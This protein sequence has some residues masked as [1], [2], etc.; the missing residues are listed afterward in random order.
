MQRTD[1]RM[2]ATRCEERTGI[3]NTDR[4]HHARLVGYEDTA[5]QAIQRTENGEPARQHDQP[6][7]GAQY[8]GRSVNDRDFQREAT[9]HDSPEPQGGS[10]RRFGCGCSPQDARNPNRQKG[11]FATQC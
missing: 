9:S 2:G 3:R 1:R 11:G 4:R 7:T 8:A 6:R 5:V 10:R